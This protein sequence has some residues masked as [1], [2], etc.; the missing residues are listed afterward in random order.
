MVNQ[1]L[2][3]LAKHAALR[4]VPAKDKKF[5]SASYCSVMASIYHHDKTLFLINHDEASC[6]RSDVKDKNAS[7]NNYR[8]LS[9]IILNGGF[10]SRLKV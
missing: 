1:R 8:G 7:L 6:L 10:L 9:T 5:V 2:F 3:V 4:F